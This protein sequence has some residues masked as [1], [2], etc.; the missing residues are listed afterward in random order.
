VGK[1]ASYLIIGNGIAGVTAAEVLR[2]TD[3]SSAITI[4]ADDPSPVY[5][6]PALKDLLGGHIPEKKVWARPNTFYQKHHIGFVHGRVATIAPDKHLL[7]LQNGENHGYT[8]L[9]LANGASPRQLDCPGTNLAGVSTLRTIA[10]YQEI[11]RRLPSVTHIVICGSGTLAL[12][13]AETLHAL[14]YHVTHLLRKQMLWSKVLDRTAS[15]MVLQ[16]ERRMGIDVRTEETIAE[17]VGKQGQVTKVITTSGARIPCNLLLIAIGIAPNIDFIKSSGIVC[18]RG[19]RVDAAMRTNA[20]DIYAAGDVVETTDT[21]TDQT[22]VL[23]QWFP[24]IQQARSAAYSMLNRLDNHKRGAFYNATFL[25][26]LDFVSLGITQQFTNSSDHSHS[27]QEIIAAPTPR[28]Y[29]KVLLKDGIPVGALFL[30]ERTQALAFKRAMDARVNMTPLLPNLFTATFDLDAWLDQ[31]HAPA[32]TFDIS[33]HALPSAETIT[34]AY[35]TP[36]PHPKV[37]VATAETQLN[38]QSQNLVIGR[39][40]EM[41]LSLD[42]SSVSRQH[43]TISNINGQYIL[44]DLGSAN[45]TF[46]NG[47]PLAPDKTHILQPNDTLRFGDVQFRFQLRQKLL[48]TAKDHKTQQTQK[49]PN[50][51]QHILGSQLERNMVRSIPEPLLAIASQTPSLIILM[52]DAEPHVVPLNFA[53]FADKRLSIGRT[54]DNALVLP[55]TATSHKHAELFSAPDGL[56]IRDLN[57]SNGVFVNKMRIS[58][59]YHLSHGDRIVIG[60]TLLYCSLPHITRDGQNKG[61]ITAKNG[62]NNIISTPIQN[63]GIVSNARDGERQ[64]NQTD[65]DRQTA[66]VSIGHRATIEPLSEKRVKFEIDMCI[67]CNRCMNV[68]PVPLSTQVYIADLNQ[69]TISNEIVAHVARFTHECIMCGS[70]V[71]VCPVDNHR[72]L[73]MLSLKQRLGSPWDDAIDTQAISDVLPHNW[74]IAFLISR[75][76]AQPILSNTQLVPDKYLLHLFASSQLLKLEA[77]ATLLREGEYDRDLY[78]V[79]EGRL[80]VLTTEARGKELQVAILNQGEYTGESGMLTGQPHFTT[81]RVLTPSLVLQVPEQVIQQFMELAPKVRVFFEQLNNMR[82]IEGILKR[83]ALFQGVS[84]ADI[85]TLAE[86]T[87]VQQYD[88]DE[89]L[90]SEKNGSSPAETQRSTSKERP[91]RET[92]HVLLE[93]FVKV[94]RQT[95][96]GTGQNKTNERIIAY[97]QGG[98]YFAGGLDLLGDG[99]AVT[100]TAITRTRVAQVPRLVLLALFKRYPEVG[101]RFTTRLNQ[102][103]ES[104][105]SAQSHVFEESLFNPH[106]PPKQPAD[107]RLRAG[108]H[109]LIS[110]GVVE[111]T[112]VLV[113]DLDK[114]IHC[115]ECED[116]CERRHGHS[117]LNRTGGMIVGNISIATACRQC[118][119]PVCMLCSRAGIARRPNGEVYI[120]ESCIGC[121]ICAERCPYGAITIVD[122]DEEAIS[123]ASSKR[124]NALFTKNTPKQTSKRRTRRTL[125]MADRAN[126]PDRHVAPGPLTITQTN[127]AYDELRKKIAIK[128]D[129]CAGYNDQACVQ[130]CPTGAAIRVQ[131]TKFF[132]STEEILRKRVH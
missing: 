12:E 78:F 81:V 76:R 108:L 69:A 120:T 121:G 17:I 87:G 130:A 113:I 106:I 105:A 9:L 93:G 56:Y 117:R 66:L 42:H 104:S 22:R 6:R 112:E 32:A 38:P 37:Q 54:Q 44:R 70:C 52:K 88:R 13:S 91:A 58:N 60:N 16:E 95:S 24:A 45:G 119:D 59:S 129:L 31:Q 26:G 50:I 40:P 34:Y 53:Q 89:C 36:I 30:G 49:A 111:G 101:Q 64:S 84:D 114:C 99:R 128:C 68:C 2:S 71:P 65:A 97:R 102:Y 74:S 132:G 46:V 47:L 79:L 126:V 28:S 21:I 18:G 61:V 103:I 94:A 109:S 85:H 124:F 55:D 8:K 122:L 123:S 131:P 3:K 39:L 98:D 35:L 115:N 27:Y 125:P 51:F 75:L 10:D 7:Q 29:R 127:T 33:L 15:D 48:N 90:F 107:A 72:D 1:Q 57:S 80:S 83:M 14:G 116:A 86:Q 20:P 25:C 5:Y 77:G 43:A 96:A 110:D 92:L 73:L 67:G 100:V 19:V 63:T 11:L 62:I 82:S 4:V 41:A 23:G 118:Q